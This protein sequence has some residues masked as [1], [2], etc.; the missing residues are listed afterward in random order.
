MTSGGYI[1][2]S[3]GLCSWAVSCENPRRAALQR[4]R[5]SQGSCPGRV[6]ADIDIV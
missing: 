4:C 2:R 3:P 5:T 1:L 6:Y